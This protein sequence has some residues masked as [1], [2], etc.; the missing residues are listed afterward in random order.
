MDRSAILLPTILVLGAFSGVLFS[1]L[2]LRLACCASGVDEP[3]FLR[4]VGIVSFIL[5][6]T[7]ILAA[8]LV[9]LLGTLAGDVAD[10]V[11]VQ[12]WRVV[13]GVAL[14]PMNMVV[15][16][17]VYRGMLSTSFHRGLRVWLAQLWIF[18]SFILILGIMIGAVLFWM[19]V[20][21][22]MKTGPA[23]SLAL[24]VARL[25]SGSG[26]AGKGLRA[27]TAV[28]DGTAGSRSRRLAPWRSKYAGGRG[29]D[30]TLG[31]GQQA[32]NGRIKAMLENQRCAGVAPL[33]GE[34]FCCIFFFDIAFGA[35]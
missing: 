35:V 14:L 25:R 6:L 22:E 13:L 12:M 33:R 27:K 23:E 26:R 1:A 34:N 11:K 4:G 3:S 29:C 7:A 8:P 20:D 31:L 19:E 9:W 15:S 10:P 18:A 30:G 2:I 16:A 5:I 24:F 32:R 21:Q 17:G 28:V